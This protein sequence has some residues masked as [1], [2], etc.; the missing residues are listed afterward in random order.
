MPENYHRR[1]G[2]VG[3]ALVAV[4]FFLLL[5]LPLLKATVDYNV[6]RIR[7]EL[8]ASLLESS[9]PAAFQALSREQLSLG[10]LELDPSAARERVRTLL[11]RNM[12]AARLDARLQS[13]TVSFSSSYRPEADG[14]WL[15]GNRPAIMP[16]IS[17]RA[18]WIFRDGWTCRVTDGVEL[19]LD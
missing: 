11:E 19:I 9:L 3:L 1:R 4:L 12:A 6:Q 14:H 15:S 13:L 10:R 7:R 2:A 8:C 18:E 5:I 17:A 16:V